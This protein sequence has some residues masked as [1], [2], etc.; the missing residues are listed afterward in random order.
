MSFIFALLIL[1]ISSVA[2]AEGNLASTEGMKVVDEF[3]RMEAA[4]QDTANLK[5]AKVAH[6]LTKELSNKPNLKS[7]RYSFK[8]YKIIKAELPL[9]YVKIG[10]FGKETE[11]W[12]GLIVFAM[13]KENEKYVIKAKDTGNGYFN[14]YELVRELESDDM[15]VKN[16]PETPEI[17]P[18]GKIVT[19]KAWGGGQY[20]Y[21]GRI[22][23]VV[24][25]RKT[26]K[27]I[28]D[29]IFADGTH[30]N[31]SKDCSEGKFLEPLKDE[32]RI[33]SVNISCFYY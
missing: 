31:P 13:V 30:L 1:F 6:L 23:E 8:R 4:H 26:Y 11:P 14:A 28:V 16:L 3:M 17:Y 7:N 5:L 10:M 2:Y 18:A 27:V 19:I 29:K 20:G 24:S 12:G 15:F 33:L 9:V 32:G 25:H 22:V 21:S